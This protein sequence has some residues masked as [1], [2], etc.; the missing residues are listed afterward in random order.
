MVHPIPSN[1]LPEEGVPGRGVVR[2]RRALL[3]HL[4][5]L[6]LLEAAQP[7]HALHGAGELLGRRERLPHERGQPPHVPAREEHPVWPGQ[8][9]VPVAQ[10]VAPDRAG[11]H[12]A[13]AH[14]LEQLLERHV[15]LPPPQEVPQRDHHVLGV[16]ADVHHF[17]AIGVRGDGAREQ[18]VWHVRVHEPRGRELLELGFLPV[19]EDLVEER[20]AV[21]GVEAEERV[22]LGSVVVVA[23]HGGEGERFEP[24]GA[25]LGVAGEDH[26]V[27]PR[28]EAALEDHGAGHPVLGKPEGLVQPE[29]EAG[30]LLVGQSC[31]E[32]AELFLGWALRDCAVVDLRERDWAGLR[33]A[34]GGC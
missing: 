4:Q 3:V 21:V 30:L 18:G 2:P 32:I 22:R 28:D 12:G 33:D 29:I 10:H 26:V 8:A 16:P 31:H 20:D 17:A 5:P 6:H 13:A 1:P 25:A 15:R 9:R 14:V 7:H 19:G 27:G 34:G 24:G 23:G 11:R